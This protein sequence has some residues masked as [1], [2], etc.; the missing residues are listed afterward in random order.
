VNDF[1]PGH[2]AVAW[3]GPGVERSIIDG[4]YLSPWIKDEG[5][6]ANTAT[7][8]ILREFWRGLLAKSIADL[9]N[10]P[11][12]LGPPFI[13]RASITVSGTWSRGDPQRIEAG[14]TMAEKDEGYWVEVD[15]KVTSFASTH[16]IS[17]IELSDGERRLNV[18]VTDPEGI[19]STLLD[20]RIRVRGFCR[21][22][23]NT[24]GERVA[25][26]LWMISLKDIAMCEPKEGSAAE[27]FISV[28][29]L[30]QNGFL[31]D[32]QTA[33]VRGRVVR[34]EQGILMIEDGRSDVS[35]YVSKDGKEWTKLGVLSVS[36]GESALAG[37]AVVA[38]DDAALNTAIFDQVS[39]IA[40]NW[41]STDVGTPGRPGSARFDGSRFVVQ[42]GGLD[43]WDNRPQQ[44]HFAYAP[45]SGD[46]TMVARLESVEKTTGWAKVGVMIR[47]SLANES[48]FGFV[49]VTPENGAALQTRSTSGGTCSTTP[50][51][52]AWR[53]PI[54]IKLTRE[55]RGLPMRP[56]FD[57]NH[58][59]KGDWVEAAGRVKWNEQTALLDGAFIRTVK[60]SK[61]SGQALAQAPGGEPIKTILEL[62]QLGLDELQRGYPVSLRGVV[63]GKRY[64]GI[65]VQDATGGVLVFWV[66]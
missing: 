28:F 44:F 59:S 55:T 17:T 62:R 61:L 2:V 41:T 54:W 21:S 25:G 12:L 3:E 57:P 64:N 4:R 60:E 63:T 35:G 24:R 9:E 29:D 5:R 39:G 36:L 6:D 15:G 30:R 20:S 33:R 7:G 31:Y 19:A 18:Y 34:N 49:A 50:F 10:T 42:G 37:L 22:I 43:I 11:P 58:I 32:G 46:H 51:P 56:V 45:F 16:R 66:P 13:D 23:L 26:E 8:G 14:Q 48:P 40:S 27:R 47:D 52:N 65:F 53:A 1:G 38:N